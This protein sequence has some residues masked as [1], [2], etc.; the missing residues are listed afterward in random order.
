[1]LL[2]PYDNCHSEPPLLAFS[3]KAGLKGKKAVGAKNLKCGFET[4][5]AEDFLPD[6]FERSCRAGVLS[7]TNVP[8]GTDRMAGSLP[9]RNY[10]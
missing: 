10:K 5:V 3:R 7:G 8:F 6:P 2:G 9:H 4:N 1:M